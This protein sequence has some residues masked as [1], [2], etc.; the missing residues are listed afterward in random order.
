MR[1]IG[2]IPHPNFKIT[3]FKMDNRLSVK[4][5]SGFN[6][7]TYKFRASS[8]LQNFTDVERLVDA[9]F[10]AN[11]QEAFVQMEAT[12]N[13]VMQRFYPKMREEFEEII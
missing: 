9:N 10:V 2:D 12:K 3:V 11:V 1:I 5:E 6:E 4:F 8:E 13:G 7:Q